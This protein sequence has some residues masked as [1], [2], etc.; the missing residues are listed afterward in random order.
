M[1][2]LPGR[3]GGR[4]FILAGAF[5]CFAFPLFLD[6]LLKCLVLLYHVFPLVS[7]AEVS[8]GP[9]EGKPR[10]IFH[11]LL[12]GSIFTVGRDGEGQG[13]D[14]EDRTHNGRDNANRPDK[15]AVGHDG[16]RVRRR[17]VLVGSRQCIMDAHT[18]K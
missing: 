11:K 5:A 3:A 7:V 6:R 14:I 15:Y 9:F 16:N 13:Y 10:G 18:E 4:N 12:P 1:T 8:N 17:A 2:R